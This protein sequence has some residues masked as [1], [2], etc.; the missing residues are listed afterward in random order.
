MAR[1]RIISKRVGKRA[2]GTLTK[3][4]KDKVTQG[5]NKVLQGRALWG[6]EELEEWFTNR[7]SRA[8]FRQDSISFDWFNDRQ[9][10]EIT[11]LTSRNGINYSGESINSP[12]ESDQSKAR[13]EVVLYSNPN[14]HILVGQ[15]VWEDGRTE[16]FIAQFFPE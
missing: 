2:L 15:G 12:G 5:E 10:V 6:D 7:I 1:K 4:S 14:G 3:S 13:I 9:L 11:H 8:V 16:M